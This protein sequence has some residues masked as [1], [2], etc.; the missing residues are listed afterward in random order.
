MATAGDAI[1]AALAELKGLDRDTIR[2][3]RRQKFLEIG[4]KLA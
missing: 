4:R 1:A 3:L 2:S